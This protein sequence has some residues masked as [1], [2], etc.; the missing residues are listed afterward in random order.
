[1]KSG[2]ALIGLFAALVAGEAR[3]GI[4]GDTLGRCAVAATSQ[5]DRTALMRWMFITASAN[6]GLSD[7]ASVS[8]EERE[9]N[10]RMVAG[11]FNRIMLTDCRREAVAALR[12]EGQAGIQNGFGALGQLAGMELMTTPSAVEAM[13]GLDRYIDEE[14]LRRMA[15]EAASRPAI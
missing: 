10:L 6:P 5:A 7:L 3:A 9:S 8:S 2:M 1:M 14:G 4:Y 13:R 11:M 12:H 15:S